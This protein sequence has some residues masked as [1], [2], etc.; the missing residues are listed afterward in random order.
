MS[1][2]IGIT[3]IITSLAAVIALVL[4][5]ITIYYQF[6]WVSHDLKVLV[7]GESLD[8][9]NAPLEDTFTINLAFI[10]KGNQD[11]IVS[12]VS[13]VFPLQLPD[14]QNFF[15]AIPW[16]GIGAVV[17]KPGEVLLKKA[18]FVYLSGKDRE[19]TVN[20]FLEKSINSNN[21]DDV[22]KKEAGKS[23]MFVQKGV[24]IA[25]IVSC[26]DLRDKP[27]FDLLQSP[28]EVLSILEKYGK[29]EAEDTVIDALIRFTVINSV[30]EIKTVDLK[31]VKINI[32]NKSIRFFHV[33]QNVISLIP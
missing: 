6:I 15:L 13:M 24:N 10:N 31:N 19:G 32:R 2:I 20:L 25:D 1:R 14:A 12:K 28:Y 18:E 17:I 23:N 33:Q 27:F 29:K 8:K 16:Y 3:N 22:S 9:P 7:T 4:S 5:S 11:T 21:I 26:L 30:G